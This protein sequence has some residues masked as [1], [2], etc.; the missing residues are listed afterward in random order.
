MTMLRIQ[1]LILTVG[2]VSVIIFASP[3][4]ADQYSDTIDIFKQ[5]PVVQSFFDNCYGYAV[6]PTVGKGGFV[7]GGAYGTGQVYA[8]SRVT[9][10]ARMI[11]ATVGLQAGGQAYSQMLF[12]QDKR[13]YADFTSGTFELDANAS[14]VA[15]TA[16]VQAKAGTSGTTAGMNTGSTSSRQA[17]TR[18][19][20]GMAVFVHATGG[21]MYEATVGGQ[22]FTFTPLNSQ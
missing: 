1:K 13:A 6:F 2:L 5:S 10:T 15:I 8:E 9:G 22:K 21:F 18:Y 17:N 11:K 20:K 4:L 7:V 19:Y 16:G 3:V 14:A 12:F